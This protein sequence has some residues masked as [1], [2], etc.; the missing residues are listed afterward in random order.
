MPRTKEALKQVAQGPGGPF[1]VLEVR[2]RLDT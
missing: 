2:Y 1:G